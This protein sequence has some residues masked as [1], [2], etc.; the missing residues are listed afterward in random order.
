MAEN[1]VEEK[2][3]TTEVPSEL[4]TFTQEEY[5][6]AL[7]QKD[8]AYQGLQ[9]VINKKD[10]HIGNLEQN[11][12]GYDGLKNT[13]NRLEI[14]MAYRKE[15]PEVEGES[16]TPNI[17]EILKQS[18]SRR[19]TEK[20]QE[21]FQ[22]NI[23]DVKELIIDAGLDP[24][25]EDFAEAEFFAT[26]GNFPLAKKKVKE[27]IGSKSSKDTDPK[28]TETLEEK[29][30]KRAQEILREKG[31]FRAESA[32]PSGRAGSF[33]E[34]EEKFLK[35]LIPLEEYTNRARKEGKQ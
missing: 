34:F 17:T 23:S 32:T 31:S 12:Q 6:T 19:Q 7:A 5:D 25:D 21:Q 14:E 3:E 27:V 11:L 24:N 26:H 28:D 4:K 22:K 13:V 30:E 2:V 15:E 33:Q 9:K 16:K 18:E 8:S 1:K 35:G 29:A 10:L 20:N